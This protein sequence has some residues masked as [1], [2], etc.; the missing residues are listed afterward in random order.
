M[1][2]R[3]GYRPNVGIILLNQKNEVFWAKRI[4]EN[5]WQFP[6][7]G[8]NYGENPTQ[9]M[10]RELYEELGLKP[11]HVRILARTRDW[12]RYNV[13]D[14]YIRRDS[15]GIYHGQKQIWFLL[16]LMAH[17]SKISLRATSHP[18]FDAWRWSTYWVPLDLVIEFKHQVYLRALQELR[19]QLD[20]KLVRDF[21]KRSGHSKKTDSKS[22][23][24]RRSR[25]RRANGQAVEES[26]KSAIHSASNSASK[27]AKK[28]R[29]T[30]KGSTATKHKKTAS[31]FRTGQE[32]TD[33]S[34][35]PRKYYKRP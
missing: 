29:F 33:K 34:S 30:H 21:Q 15:R 28:P 32:S 25:H 27:D 19:I 22:G 24:Y 14:N 1:L 20:L 2:D 17:E 18:E 8:I 3:Q 16:R 23:L 26:C 31:K 10:Y 4:R 11:G 13:P 5:S 7:G 12:L 6:Q 35:S 9:A